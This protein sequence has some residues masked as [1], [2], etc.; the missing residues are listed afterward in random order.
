MLVDIAILVSIIVLSILWFWPE[1][2]K[3]D[4]YDDPD[5]WGSR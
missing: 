5:N 3:G 1:R 2:E 4:P